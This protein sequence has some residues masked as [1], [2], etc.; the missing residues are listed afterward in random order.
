VA[1]DLGGVLE[2]L[3]EDDGIAQAEDLRAARVERIEDRG[4]RALGIGGDALAGEA[5]E[6]RRKGSAVVQPDGV[7][8]MLADGVGDLFG[9]HEQVGGAV[10]IDDGVGQSDRRVADVVAADIESPGDRIEGGEHH[11]VGLALGKPL[12]DLGA[13][14]GGGAAGGGIVL[15][16]QRRIRGRGAIGPDRVDRI[17]VDR[18]QLGALLGE[19]LLRF[20]DPGARVQPGVVADAAAIGGMFAQPDA[21]LVAGTETYCH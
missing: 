5:L 15:H 7:A 16:A 11:R 14:G 13:L 8:E 1:G 12:G 4:D 6:R 21:M 3:G 20:L 17:G 18:D 10:G 2:C 19:R 9:A